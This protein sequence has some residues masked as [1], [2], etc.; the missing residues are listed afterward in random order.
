MSSHEH[1]KDRTIQHKKIKR[2]LPKI[3][4]P[5]KKNKS[6][7]EFSDNTSPIE[8]YKGLNDRKDG[9]N[10]KYDEGKEAKCPDETPPD[11]MEK[12]VSE[13]KNYKN[14]K[15]MRETRQNYQMALLLVIWRKV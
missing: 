14:E 9:K 3:A 10:K 8:D 12:G 2:T 5:A 7:T 4:S 11:D 6:D 15:L 13:R 1:E